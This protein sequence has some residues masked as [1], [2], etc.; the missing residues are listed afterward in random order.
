MLPE[1]NAVFVPSTKRMGTYTHEDVRGMISNPT[2]AGFGPF[3]Q[4]IPDEMWI[5]TAIKEI[6]LQGATQF[7][8]NMLH[9]L[10]AS[11]A[12]VE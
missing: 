4:L 1:P 7:L 8:V 12:K 2:Y 6:E 5:Q 9:V 10:R 3:P 11:F